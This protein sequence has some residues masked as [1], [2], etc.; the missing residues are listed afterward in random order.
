MVP[1]ENLLSKELQSP[2]PTG[3]GTENQVFYYIKKPEK[4][5]IVEY[6]G[7]RKSIFKN[8]NR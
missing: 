8:K 6:I 7:S 3:H 1:L 5:S 2:V 4:M